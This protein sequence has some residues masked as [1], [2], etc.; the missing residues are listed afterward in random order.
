MDILK[1]IYNKIKLRYGI[2]VPSI[3][4]VF[5]ILSLIASIW[6]A[7]FLYE[8]NIVDPIYLFA[9]LFFPFTSIIIGIIIIIK[10]IVEAI[11]KKEGSHLKIVIVFIMGLM[12]VL[13]SII[14]S[15]VSTYIIKTNLDLFL[16]QNLNSSVSYIIDV[17]NNE[18]INKQ[19]FMSN[20]ISA[21]G[22][23]YFNDIYTNMKNGEFDY[24]IINNIIQES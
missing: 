24:N 23:D 1:K 16:D 11:Q 12:T 10:F 8:P 21:L 7:G 2:V 5:T 18:I 22:V 19:E 17:S 20:T 13:P 9:V 6:I 3:I 4:V 15:K 14:V